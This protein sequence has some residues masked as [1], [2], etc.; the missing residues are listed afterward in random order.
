[1]GEQVFVDQSLTAGLNN[2]T[3][4][5]PPHAAAGSTFARFRVT[6]GRGYS[7]S[8]LAPDGEVE[9]Y[10][11]TILPPC[12]TSGMRTAYPTTRANN[13]ARHVLGSGLFLGSGV[14]AEGDGQP[15]AN[16]LG[17]DNAG[18]DEDGVTFADLHEGDTADVTVTATIPVTAV[19]NAWIDFNGDGDWGDTG[20][21]IFVNQALCAGANILTVAVPSGAALGTTMAR[22]RVTATG[23]YTYSGLAPDGEV[24]DYQVT[25]LEA[26][27]DFGDAPEAGTSY[28][29]S[30]ANNG[31]RH[32]LGSSLY[33]GAGVD[34]EADGQ[35]D[36]NAL[37]ED[38]AGDD[39]DGVTFSALEAGRTA[40]VNVTAT[41][42]STAVLNAWMDFNADGDWTDAG[43]QIYVD[44]ALSVG[45]NNLTVV[46]PSTAVLGE[47]FARFRVTSS[48]GH[49]FSGLAPDGEVE[50][51][52]VTI[53]ESMGRSRT[54]RFACFRAGGR[55]TRLVARWEAQLT[56]PARK[57][58]RHS[59]SS[60][61]GES[62]RSGNGQY[63][64]AR[65]AAALV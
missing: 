15:D 21:Q 6:S 28:P 17:D 47:T 65:E 64:V 40:D 2:L 60:C 31:A 25:V 32:I 20:E 4:S 48:G 63:G 33:L 53:T 51:Y 8:D 57:T 5:I 58:G 43:E 3:L 27:K 56:S 12:W 59:N 39:E 37:G 1:M 11:V 22:F 44:L 10:Q 35:P 61:R 16:A 54:C 36:A 29:T 45:L 52:R 19:L 14:D 18:D 50:D 41:I 9:D 42:P 46:I 34:A 24:E 49:S 13:G 30:R 55:H 26:P 7:F 23:G 38:N 62:H